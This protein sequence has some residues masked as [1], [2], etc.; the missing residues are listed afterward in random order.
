[1]V[2]LQYHQTQ[3]SYLLQKSLT[4][5]F[6]LSAKQVFANL[7][8]TY[9]QFNVVNI[10]TLSFAPACLNCIRSVYVTLICIFR[11]HFDILSLVQQYIWSTMQPVNLT[12]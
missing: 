2:Q 3:D 9:R 7:S 5:Q 4:V 8:P 11:L 12:S 10:V 1:M 6:S